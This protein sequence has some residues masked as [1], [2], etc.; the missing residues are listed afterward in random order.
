MN[1]N[2][3]PSDTMKD[4]QMTKPLTYLANHETNKQVHVTINLPL[5]ASPTVS[6]NLI[7]NSSIL[8]SL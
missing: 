7:L 8:A 5:R 1:K 2:N 3:I 4:E 6:L